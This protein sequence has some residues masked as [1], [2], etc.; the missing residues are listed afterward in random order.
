MSNFS[1]SYLR[2]PFQIITTHL[3]IP[4]LLRIPAEVRLRAVPDRNEREN[5]KGDKWKTGGRRYDN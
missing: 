3:T 5:K 4:I 2:I 1:Q